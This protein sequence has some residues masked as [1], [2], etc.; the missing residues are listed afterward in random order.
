MNICYNDFTDL[1]GI[2]PPNIGAGC[3]DRANSGNIDADPFFVDQL[4]GDFHI[5]S[6]SPCINAGFNG[7]P[8]IPS[9]DKDGF[10]R[11][12]PVGGVVDM[13]AYEFGGEICND[14]VDNDEDGLVDCDDPDCQ[15][16]N[17]NDGHNALPCGDDCD[18]N[19]PGVNPAAQEICDD[20]K[21]NDCD[22]LVDCDDLFECAGHPACIT[23]TTTTTTTVP[24][25]TTTTSTTTTTTTTLV[26]R[27]PDDSRHAVGCIS[28]RVTNLAGQPLAGKTVILR[29]TSPR[30]RISKRTVTN[31]NGCYHFT[32][33]EDG[34]YKIKVR[35]CRNVP[36]HIV[37]IAGGHGKV[38]DVNFGCR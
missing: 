21:D 32:D 9:N 2:L 8:V 19:D 23:T 22:G 37:V 4:Q 1:G 11:I 27:C 12:L 3:A 35:G 30:P 31:S 7:A 17:D 14:G 25:T 28:G 29:R 20:G 33:L 34:T 18:D 26:C 10:P 16:D 15:V 13:G 6:G 5:Q 38:N 24:T 36:P